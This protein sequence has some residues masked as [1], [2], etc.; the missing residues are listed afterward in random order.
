M[1]LRI[2]HRHSLFW[3]TNNILKMSIL[4]HNNT[5]LTDFKPICRGKANETPFY[6]ERKHYGNNTSRH[7]CFIATYAYSIAQM[8][9]NYFT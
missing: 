9:P 1:H 4:N 8:N 3:Q 7:D 5:L 2:P 6:C